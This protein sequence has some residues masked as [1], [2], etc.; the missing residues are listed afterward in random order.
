MN[1]RFCSQYSCEINFPDKL[2]EMNKHL[3]LINNALF[4][5]VT[6]ALPKLVLIK[7]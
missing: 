4:T 7:F 1:F 3:N 6:I 5:R 2:F